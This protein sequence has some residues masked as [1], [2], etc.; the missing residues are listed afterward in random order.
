MTIRILVLD[1]DQSRHD[2][3]C[4]RF[5]EAGMPIVDVHV[6]TAAEA[7][8]ELRDAKK[9]FDLVF[10]DHDLGGRVNVSINDAGTGSEVARFLAANPEVYHRH[11]AFVVHSFNLLGAANMI[12]LIGS[13][14]HEPGCWTKERFPAHMV[15]AI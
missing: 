11:G 7:I 9:A 13:A 10:L 14:T 2:E 15:K 12:R 6:E 1:D 3:F 8:A 4:H 5:S